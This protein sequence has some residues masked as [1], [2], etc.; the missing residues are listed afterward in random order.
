MAKKKTKTTSSSKKG[1]HKTVKNKTTKKS[2][3]KKKKVNNIF[4][5]PLGKAIISIAIIIIVL[6][7][8]KAFS[9]LGG[10]TGNESINDTITIQAY[11]DFGCPFSAKA[12]KTMDKLKQTYGENIQIEFKHFPV[13]Q[14]HPESQLAHEA[15]EC[16][17]D[18]DKF[19]AYSEKL[20]ENQQDH[21]KQDLVD[22]ASA[23]QLNMEEFNSCLDGREKKNIV[24]KE[25]QEGLEKGV[26][27]TPTFFIG[28]NKIVGAKPITE[29][30]DA[31]SQH[32]SGADSG[33]SQ[34]SESLSLTVVNDDRCDNCDVSQVITSLEQL[35]GEIDVNY[36]DY[37]SDEGSALYES[38]GLSNLPALLFEKE[39]TEK[40][41]FSQLES[42]IVPK[43]DK[44]ML[45]IGAQ[46]DPTKEICDNGKDDTG[47]GKIDCDDSACLGTW[48]CAKKT[49]KP[50]VELFVMAYCPY[51]T[52]M[53]KAM[54]PVVETLGDNIDFQLKFVDYAMHDKKEIDEQIIQYCIQ[55]NNEEKL[56]PYLKCFLE[57]GKTDACLSEVGISKENINSCVEK[58][59]KKFGITEAYEDDTQWKGRFPPFT[60]HKEDNEKYNVKGSPHLVING[61]Q[62]KVGRNPSAL[63]DAVCSKFIEAPEEC[64]E[65]LS[66]KTP[67][68]GFGFK[69]STESS[70]TAQCG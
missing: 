11:N 4:T 37:K 18:Q 45:N 47:N 33:K 3:N 35:L 54:L 42:Y 31:I 59:D 17:K 70:S 6:L 50:K 49:E 39:V 15:S 46:F 36:L 10:N 7:L 13:P 65:T 64:N 60:I 34:K 20:F 40:E 1:P 28:D 8:A 5:K 22:Y 19:K 9:P 32:T 24:Q 23:L 44:L 27:G 55:N 48:E 53:E 2:N 21:S 16:A 43:E 14:L 12:Q 38:A 58:T 63:L 30:K 62:P 41:G 66:S 52:M 61:A 57:D 29:F 26:S 67:S 68:S 25:F 69:E 56:L 51:G